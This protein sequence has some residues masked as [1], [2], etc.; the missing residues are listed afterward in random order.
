MVRGEG[1]VRG[2]ARRALCAGML[3]LQ[4]VVLFLTGVVSVGLTD[5]PVWVALGGGLALAVLCVVA[6]A[7]LRTQAGYA[8]GWLIQLVSLALGFVVPAMFFLGVV[9]GA[10]W[11]T[12]YVLGARIDRER[13]ERQVLEKEWRDEPS[14]GSTTESGTERP[15]GE[16]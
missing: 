10:L 5:V 6:A 7:V 15:S 14:T 16:T 13:A 11:A 4:A 2:S 9:F 1:A 3:V 8:L 12:A